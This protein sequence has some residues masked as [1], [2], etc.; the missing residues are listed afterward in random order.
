[1]VFTTPAPFVLL[2]MLS[3]AYGCTVP[4]PAT[5]NVTWDYQIGGYKNR[6][7]DVYMLDGF[8][9]QSTLISTLHD[10]GKR[11]SCYFSSQYESFRP[12]AGSFPSSLLGHNLD[13]WPGERWVDIRQKTALE[14]IYRSRLTRAVDLKCDGV[15]WDNID[16]YM[17]D[18]SGFPVTVTDGVSFIQSLITLTHGYN[19]SFGL[20]NVPNLVAQFVQA[21]DYSINEDCAKY[22]EC[23]SYT[24]FITAGKP[25]FSVE[26]TDNTQ[27]STNAKCQAM[28]NAQMT[29]PIIRDRGV[30]ADGSFLACTNA[31]G[32]CS[33]PAGPGMSTGPTGGGDASSGDTLSTR[34]SP[35]LAV[36]FFLLI[37]YGMA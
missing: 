12:D 26:Y 31:A 30:K 28:V 14:P 11:V 20:K 4:W 34:G 15:E 37:V 32:V 24:P 33:P 36:S 3:S 2:L 6:D 17:D 1:M 29:S 10:Q 5:I 8:L 22:N 21:A 23:G 25:A 13:S 7:V 9:T 16:G 35:W 19:I 18:K 27:R